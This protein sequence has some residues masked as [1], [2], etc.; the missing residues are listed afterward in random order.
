MVVDK[1]HISV[2]IAKQLLFC[3]NKS[4]FVSKVNIPIFNFL[5]IFETSA[6]LTICSDSLVWIELQKSSN[7]IKTL[8]GYVRYEVLQAP[9]LAG[10]GTLNDRGPV[11]RLYAV[12]VTLAR[13]RNVLEDALELV[14]G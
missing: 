12:N 7:Q 1:F 9:L 13:L 5:F 11:V 2:F 3:K 10:G 14:E 6:Q 4:R 8:L